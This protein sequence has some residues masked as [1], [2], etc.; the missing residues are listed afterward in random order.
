MKRI[1]LTLLGAA[2]SLSTMSTAFAA[3]AG[4]S[5]AILGPTGGPRD[6]LA[7]ASTPTDVDVSIV[8]GAPVVPYEYSL[9]NSCWFT[10]KVSTPADSYERFDLIG[11]WFVGSDGQPHSTV[12]VNN[13]PVPAGSVCKVFVAHNN[14]TV[15]GS[16]TTYSVV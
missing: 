6:G 1:A 12:S 4:G 7:H 3:P 2:L 10:G 5:T 15:K 9:V 16:T 8:G 13:N 14:T 11:P